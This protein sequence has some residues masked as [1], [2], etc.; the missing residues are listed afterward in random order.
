MSITGSP[1]G[2]CVFLFLKSK[3]TT[4]SLSLY[5]SISHFGGQSK[6]NAIGDK[7]PPLSTCIFDIL[8]RGKL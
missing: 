2:S 7:P 8:G 1:T 5:L 3:L 4:L 6:E